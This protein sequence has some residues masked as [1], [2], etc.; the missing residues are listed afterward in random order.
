MGEILE[1]EDK[2]REMGDNKYG[3]EEGRIDMNERIAAASRD[4]RILRRAFVEI[5]R[6]GV[7]SQVSG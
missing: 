6:P 7:T 2:S 1:I 5:L 3:K 4:W